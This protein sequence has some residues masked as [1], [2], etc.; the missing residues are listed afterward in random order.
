M[1]KKGKKK[2]PKKIKKKKFHQNRVILDLLPFIFFDDLKHIKSLSFTKLTGATFS[3]F[4]A[5]C[6][7][8]G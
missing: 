5:F 3:F 8:Q 6:D 7:S 1:K 4:F 2:K